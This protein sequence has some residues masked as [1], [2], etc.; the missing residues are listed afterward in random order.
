M[1]GP[2]RFTVRHETLYRYSVPVVL[3]PHVLRLTPRAQDQ[4]QTRS[5]MVQPEPVEL[6]EE[7]DAY[8]NRVVRAKFSDRATGELRI[9][10][11]FELETPPPLLVS[12]VSQ[13]LPWSPRS[14]DDL[15]VYQGAF[16]DAATALDMTPVC[17]SS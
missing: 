12:E 14:V 6:H 10:S 7:D 9:D 3:A 4:I 8:G 17:S 16:V 5:L 2:M 13:R 11:R 15:G 1:L